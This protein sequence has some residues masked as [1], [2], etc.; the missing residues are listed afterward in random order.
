MEKKQTKKIS[1]L[2]KTTNSKKNNEPLLQNLENKIL[3]L[4]KLEEELKK[5]NILLFKK[6]EE[7]KHLGT[8]LTDAGA[9]YKMLF[10]TAI[11]G[12][13]I[14]DAE[15][16]EIADINPSL[17]ELL[18]YPKK[19]FI[20]EKIWEIKSFKDITA[21]RD[22]FLE[23]QEK[24]Y[25]RYDNLPLETS[26]GNMINVEFVSKI[27]S[28]DHQKVVQCNIKDISQYKLTE[29]ALHASQ[30]ITE[31]IINT[32][33][34]RVFWKDKDLIYLGC[35]KLF[36]QDAGF[37]DPKDIVGKDDYEMGWRN[38]AEMYRAD[39]RS[40]IE[41]G[42]S[43][44]LIEES[45]TTPDGNTI[46][47]LT[48]KV[49][50]RSSKGEII[51]VLGTYID[52]TERKIA[53]ETLLK[54]SLVVEQSPISVVITNPQGDIEYVNSK[55]CQVTG[56]SSEEV[57]G[58][59][60]R[61]LKSDLQDEKF[62]QELWVTILSGKEWK[63]EILNKKKNGDLYWES[64]LISPLVNMNGDITHFVAVKA[65]ITEQKKIRSA[66]L[67]SE[68]RYKA[69][70]NTSLELIYIFNLEGQFIEANAQALKIFG[71]TYEEAKNLKISD[72]LLPEDLPIA[73]K[74]IEYVIANK[75]NKGPQEYRIKRKK[76]EEIFI[77]TTGVRLDR[78]GTPYA[79]LGIARDIT[80]RKKAVELLMKNE[81]KFNRLAEQS[82]NLIFIY[83]DGSIVYANQKCVD[84]MGYSKEEFYSDDFNFF[85]LIDDEFK[86]IIRQNLYKHSQDINVE[87]IDY[88]IVTK[89]GLKLN[90]IISTELIDYADGK[91]IMGTIMDIT[92][93]KLAENKLAA[94]E[95]RYRLLFQSAAEGILAVDVET[96]KLTLVNK[97]A[98]EM[99]GYTEQE[100]TGLSIATL[101]PVEFLTEIF[102]LFKEQA[103]AN[104]PMTGELPCKRKDGTLFY[105][106]VNSVTVLIDNKKHS[107]GFFTD[108]TAQ[109]EATEKINLF[110]TLVDHSNDKIEL[111]DLETGRYLDCNKNAYLELGYTREEFLSLKIFDVDKVLNKDNFTERIAVLR[112][113]ESLLIE[114][115][116]RRKDGTEFPVEINIKVV[117]LE[118]EY[119]IAIVRNIT[120]RKLYEQELIKAKENA[121]EMNKLKTIFLANM[122][123]ELR[124]PLIGILGNAEFLKNELKDN[125]LIEMA[126]TIKTSGQRLNSTLNNILDISKI[127]SETLKVQFE[128]LDLLKYFSESVKLF[129]PTAEAK[130]LR[131]NFEIQEKTLIVNLDEKMF[132]SIMN[133][134]ISNA[135]K[136]TENGGIKLKAKKQKNEVIIEV[137]DSGIG[138]ADEF[139]EIIFKSFRQASEGFSR[140]FE[141]SGLGLSIVKKYVDLMGGII[142]LKSKLG[143][144]STF[145]LKFPLNKQQFNI[146]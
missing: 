58:K 131:L 63:G 90:A 109:K 14:L 128:N 25:V 95:E 94:S 136:Y 93:R 7:Q 132:V 51:G 82:P 113:S 96:Q 120:E 125:E 62:F 106:K 130:G 140:R 39:D 117:K 146:F 48:S 76:G 32:I 49:P 107:I 69:I 15:T 13:L 83:Y 119:I 38:Q 123:H 91:A 33:P 85:T 126:E 64:E 31:R 78:D 29:E 71:L 138:I 129:K 87:P 89:K 43:K 60:P 24:E 26:N 105:S 22:K 47:L 108:I 70:F 5:A 135:I 145:I 81:K 127:E 110:R 92:E 122:S 12:I 42:K 112:E 77:E 99:F 67:I 100:M 133:N 124:T 74:N 114:G 84:V 17:V 139:H 27:Y 56:Y 11:D 73:L 44:L 103:Q 9:K 97:T 137:I 98:C 52:I 118:R 102:H 30:F 50:L 66:L 34:A 40:I 3:Q 86:N 6:I 141:G 36:A 37:T 61:I 4:K 111:I 115:I 55:F 46:T 10:E 53:E 41:I 21:N 116:H 19:E 88:V 8:L 23:L 16:G 121:E 28:V 2:S 101:H 142:I 143:Q 57:I 80:E 144:G 72:M 59:N 45:Q 79:I 54:L 18:G 65:D 104:S 75:V 35:N 68:E 20:G 1:S 134:L